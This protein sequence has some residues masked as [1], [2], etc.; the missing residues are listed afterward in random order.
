MWVVIDHLRGARR[1]QRQEFELK[2]RLTV[3]RHPD[4]DV[5]FDT[6]RDLEASTRHA[7]LRLKGDAVRLVDVGSSNGTYVAKTRVKDVALPAGEAT[8]VEFGAD[9]PRLRI[10]WDPSLEPS[11]GPPLP[12]RT[13]RLLL[14]APIALI[15]FI[16]TMV[17]IRW[18]L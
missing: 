16:G 5:S 9:G 14:L 15:A 1:G 4:C 7:E 2:K 13:P 10:W 6:R 17:L 11:E 8:E 12:R 3:G 18:L